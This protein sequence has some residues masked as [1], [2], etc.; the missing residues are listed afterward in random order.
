MQI[1]ND[2]TECPGNVI[3]DSV[4][5]RSFID[6][7]RV[8]NL[9]LRVNDLSRSDRRPRQGRQQQNSLATISG[10]YPNSFTARWAIIIAVFAS[11]PGA[12]S[13]LAIV[14][15]PNGCRPIFVESPGPPLA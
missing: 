6:L 3:K 13:E 14:M 2:C 9:A 7:K 10:L 8:D 12:E 15:R 11:A 1:L 5:N 4:D